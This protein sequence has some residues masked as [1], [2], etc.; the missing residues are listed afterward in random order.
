MATLLLQ[1]AC[2]RTRASRASHACHAAAGSPAPA[3][4]PASL[5]QRRAAL[6]ATLAVLVAAATPR[7]HAGALD[8]A[9]A[10][11]VQ[12][13]ARTRVERA[14][15]APTE[16]TDAGEREIH[17]APDGLMWVD[18]REGEGPLPRTGDLVVANI[19]GYLQDGSK[20]EDTQAAGAP[21][22]FTA[23]VQPAG[24]CDGLER[25]L[26]TTRAGGRRLLTVPAELGFGAAGG[27]GSLRRVPRGVSLRYEIEVLRCGP[28][29]EAGL[30]CCTQPSWPCDAPAAFAP[31]LEDAGALANPPTVN[32]L[33]GL[34]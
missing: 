34:E 12:S 30:A 19:I 6:S 3:P 15:D 8:D 31:T 29:G 32:D 16:S 4:P 1:H 25:G 26:L 5:L 9:A 2:V 18:L 22:V 10:A 13:A 11:L 14:A 17:T 24:M 27:P 20:F 33:T 7:A 23:G 28:G 21:L